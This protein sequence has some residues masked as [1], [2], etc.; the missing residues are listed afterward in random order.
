MLYRNEIFI[1]KHSENAATNCMMPWTMLFWM[2]AVVLKQVFHEISR[3]FIEFLQRLTETRFFAVSVTI[4][5]TTVYR[6]TPAG[7]RFSTIGRP[8]L[9]QRDRQIEIALT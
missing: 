1:A 7:L 9:D 5:H 2:E 8:L 4:D 6:D 3:V